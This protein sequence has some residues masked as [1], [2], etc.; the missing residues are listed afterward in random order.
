MT[1]HDPKIA[2]ATCSDA[3]FALKSTRFTATIRVPI[4]RQGGLAAKPGYLGLGNT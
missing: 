3:T 4:N 2:I 1:H